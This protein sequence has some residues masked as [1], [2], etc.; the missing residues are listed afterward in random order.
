MGTE[1]T[2][3]MR[4]VLQSIG[5]LQHHWI[6]GSMLSWPLYSHALW[7]QNAVRAVLC[8]NKMGEGIG[9]NLDGHGCILFF[10]HEV[11]GFM[12]SCKLEEGCV[13]TL[14]VF[15][16]R[17]HGLSVHMSNLCRCSVRT[18]VLDPLVKDSVGI[19]VNSHVLESTPKQSAVCSNEV[20][21]GCFDQPLTEL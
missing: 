5:C 19:P 4:D 6:M 9:A 10:T 20:K 8:S 18:L 17:C 21:L 7:S 12:G 11:A 15:C 1:T 16:N 2:V 3:N 14:V 13:Q